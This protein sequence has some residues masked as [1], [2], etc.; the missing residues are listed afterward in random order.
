MPNTDL[1]GL[2]LLDKDELIEIINKMAT[3][4]VCLSFYGKRT[5]QEIQRRVRPRSTRNIKELG[6]GKPE[7]RENRIYEGENLQAM[8][9]MY[10]YKGQI[11]LIATDPPYNTGE[12]FRYSDKWENNPN[13]TDVGTLVTLDDGSRHTKWMKAMIP[14]LQMMHAMLKPSGVLAICIDDNELFHLGMMLDEIFGEENRIAIINWQKAYSPKNDSKHVSTATEYVLVYAKTKTQT[15]TNLLPRNASMNS[16]YKNSD[17]DPEGDWTGG[18]PVAAT[19]AKKDRYAIQ[20]PFTGAL[21]YPGTGAWRNPKRD[22]KVRL[23][24]WGSKYVEADLGDGRAKALVIKGAKTPLIT[25]NSNLDH[26]PT[27]EDSSVYI[28]NEIIKARQKA[29]RIRDNEV[30]PILFFLKDGDGRPRIKRYLKDVKKGKVPLTYW[31]DDEYD[32]PIDIGTQSWSHKE[33]GHSQTGINELDQILGKGHNF[34]TVKPLKLIK[35]IIQLWCPSKGLVLDPY[36]GSG[37]TGHAVL[38]LNAETDANRKF[39]LVEQGNPETSDQYARSLT[40]ERIKRAITGER[41]A[42]D[43]ILSVSATPLQ[44]GFDYLQLTKQIDAKAVLSMKREELIDVVLS[45]HWDEGRR[46][47][48]SPL[49]R[50]EGYQFLTARNLQQEGYFIIW[51]TP[52]S[53]GQLD[54]KTYETMVKEAKK[55]ELKPPYR[56][57]ARFEIY[58]SS[59]V[60]FYKIPDKILAHLGLNEYSERY[61]EIEEGAER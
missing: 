60:I 3:G 22:M 53:V 28:S 9:T 42:T 1:D 17:N 15:R 56:V 27:V 16:I 44:G 14:R 7:D 26:N 41:P 31:A 13:D 49:I 2:E 10:K 46:S 18:D 45:S 11:D 5:A 47:D 34:Q 55:A 6:I 23:E 51:Y 32:E 29:E 48:T 12:Y 33:S 57:Y 24:S 30:W 39:I 52:D 20:S 40:R 61:N 8:V 35:K 36:A 50:I 25:N 37:T 21:H 59:S 54:S 4:G 58:Q 38:E 19:P 43:G